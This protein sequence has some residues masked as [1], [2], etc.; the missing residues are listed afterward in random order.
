M[1]GVKAPV[2]DLESCYER[3]NCKIPIM[4]LEQLTLEYVKGNFRKIQRTQIL[5]SC[6]YA[7]FYSHSR[8]SCHFETQPCKK[9]ILEY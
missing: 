9:T 2:D 4:S 3:S 1:K 6:V 7:Q 8:K 5:I